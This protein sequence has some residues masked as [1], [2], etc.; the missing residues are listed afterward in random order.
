[1]DPETDVSCAERCLCPEGEEET[2]VDDPA[3]GGPEQ[4]AQACAL[5][6]WGRGV[7][8]AGFQGDAVC[9]ETEDGEGQTRNEG[10][11]GVDRFVHKRH[12]A[13]LQ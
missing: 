8:K 5:Q 11:D 4:E 9:D 10:V 7:C 1:M 12:V 6:I 13:A 2:A 3:A